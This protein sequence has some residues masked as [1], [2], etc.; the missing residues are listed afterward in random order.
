MIID[1]KIS[2]LEKKIK[3]LQ[4]K[5][6]SS[7][8]PL[9]KGN[10]SVEENSL[11]QGV[12]L[13][14]NVHP[15][16]QEEFYKRNLLRLE[17]ACKKNKVWSKEKIVSISPKYKLIPGMIGNFEYDVRSD[18]SIYDE[19]DR[20]VMGLPTRKANYQEV[21]ACIDI[22]HKVQFQELTLGDR[23]K[24]TLVTFPE[25]KIANGNVVKDTIQKVFCNE[26]GELLK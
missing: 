21:L 5:L 24:N 6:P 11:T 14:Q 1:L 23:S 10:T 18:T 15:H 25:M 17:E 26:T 22:I 19:V 8:Y 9:I 13:G 20:L 4:S 7:F 3:F 12:K 16:E 2:I